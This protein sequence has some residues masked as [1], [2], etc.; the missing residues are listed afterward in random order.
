MT[1]KLTSYLEL[2][3]GGERKLTPT[4]L[5]T[6]LSTVRALNR[7][8]LLHEHFVDWHQFGD[9]FDLAWRDYRDPF[10]LARLAVAGRTDEVAGLGAQDLRVATSELA[11]AERIWHL[12]RET[13]ADAPAIAEVLNRARTG[14]PYP[15]WRDTY[16]IEGPLTVRFHMPL[17]EPFP[18]HLWVDSLDLVRVNVSI[19][20]FVNGFARSPALGAWLTA[21][22]AERLF[23]RVTVGTDPQES[24]CRLQAEPP[25]V[26][27]DIVRLSGKQ[28]V[29]PGT[30]FAEVRVPGVQVA[31][32]G[33][34]NGHNEE[35]ARRAFALVMQQVRAAVS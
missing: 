11:R 33:N 25:A 6:A 31:P 30:H 15:R 22:G 14:Y 3:L 12:L 16:G 34:L 1:S 21:H 23:V 17:H 26:E 13:A 27:R 10:L 18:L 19:D 4:G 7:P 5:R 28:W 32:L 29:S 20:G 9:E 2:V 8:L 24:W 35:R